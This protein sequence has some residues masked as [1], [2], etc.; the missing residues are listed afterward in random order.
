MVVVR[1]ASQSLGVGTLRSPFWIARKPAVI[2]IQA[3][4]YGEVLS[5]MLTDPRNKGGW[6][7]KSERCDWE[8]GRAF[9]T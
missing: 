4:V 9:V 5:R 3:R 8:F 7:G 1:V 6:S 2:T